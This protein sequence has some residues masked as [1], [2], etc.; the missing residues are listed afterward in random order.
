M[1]KGT[2]GGLQGMKK[3][4]SALALDM[5]NFLRKKL[6]I[7]LP[8]EFRDA[9][10]E[11]GLRMTWNPYLNRGTNFPANLRE[12]RKLRGLVPTVVETLETQ[13]ERV[14]LQL[15]EEGNTP[16]NKYS[17]LM[18]LASTNT[19]LFYK[20]LIEHLVELMPIVY[21]PTVGEAC[22]KFDRIYRNDL[23]MYFSIF[24]DKGQMSTVIN[25][26]P[27]PNVKIVVITDGGRIL[28][29]GDLGTN[30]MGISIGKVALYV[31]GGGFA[32][33]EGLPVI[34][35]AGTNREELLNDKFYL[36]TKA[37][38]IKGA[39][40]LAAVEELCTSIVEKY[41]DALIQFEDF[42][43]DDAFKILEHLRTKVLCFNDDIQGTGAVVLSG[44][45]NGM[46][47]QNTALKDV[48][49]V[50]YGAGSSAAGVSSMIV[51]L[52]HTAAGL[53]LE[54]ARKAIYMVDS[55]GL[56]TNTRGDLEKMA[57]H[58]RPFMRTDGTPDMKNLLDV[59][60]HVKPH[61]LFGLSGS[62][63]AFFQE[64]VEE[65]CKHVKTPL[66][67]PLS[68]PTSKAEITAEDAYAWSDGK[69][70]FAAGSPFAPVEYKGKTYIPGQGNNVF[71]FPG[72]GFGAVAVKAKCIPD[73]FLIDA[74]MA[75]ADHVK[76]EEIMTGKV[77]PDLKDLRSVSLAV[78][79]KV[80]E[81][82]FDMGLA[83][84]DRPDNLHQFLKEKMWEPTSWSTMMDQMGAAM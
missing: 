60:K 70:I 55:K 35:D 41:P 13:V 57:V 18:Q 26:C 45:I 49:V 54:E 11:G 27:L 23:G 22:V 9:V 43:T 40:H 59:L 29:L 8:D 78:A 17:I 74:G 81:R 51:S 52:L 84:I 65:V 61:A 39:E 53:S 77:Y 34:L 6:D 4:G 64:H 37:P 66:L 25:N 79:E 68:N 71:I 21:T 76:T 63:P 72:L 1:F 82:A 47:A 83:Q 73:E 14:M 7:N 19:L 20:V 12:S 46:K 31:A 58:K 32:P 56:I 30:G 62:G 2:E 42:Q 69:C 36:G 67:F 5:W 16:L 3:S 44:F 50:F 10:K 75:V 15:R 38:R 28:G 24:H 48:R 80:A 33:E